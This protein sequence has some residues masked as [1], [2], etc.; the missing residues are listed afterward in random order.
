MSKNPDNLQPTLPG[1]FTPLT[2]DIFFT[3]S[4]LSVLLL[5]GNWAPEYSSQYWLE[6]PSSHTSSYYVKI[7]FTQIYSLYKTGSIVTIALFNV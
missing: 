6:M 1:T 4:Q 7:N 3:L 5:N 2:I